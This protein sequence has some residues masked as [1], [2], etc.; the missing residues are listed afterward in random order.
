[1]SV[2]ATKCG[3]AYIILRLAHDNPDLT[4]AANDGGVGNR[5]RWFKAY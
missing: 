3:I 4:A 2:S 1:M 5:V